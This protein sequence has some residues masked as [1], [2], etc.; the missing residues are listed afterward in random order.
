MYTWSLREFLVVSMKKKSLESKEQFL[1]RNILEKNPTQCL[2]EV[3]GDLMES[4]V[5]FVRKVSWGICRD[6]LEKKLLEHEK[7]FLENPWRISLSK[8][9]RSLWRNATKK[10]DQFPN[11]FLEETFCVIDVSLN[12][13][14]VRPGNILKMSHNSQ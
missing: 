9:W 11:E 1:P 13:F 3:S 4:Y 6:S 8:S 12:Q 14:S 5:M 7:I 10:Q 2:A